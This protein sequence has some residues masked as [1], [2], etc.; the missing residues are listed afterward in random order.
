MRGQ[1]LPKI[2]QQLLLMAKEDKHKKNDMRLILEANMRAYRND[3]TITVTPME[4]S[5]ML[6]IY[7]EEAGLPE[8]IMRAKELDE[9]FAIDFG[10]W[11]GY[12]LLNTKIEGM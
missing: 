7:C 6:R 12:S 3:P 11:L 1:Q 8:E 9:S 10:N 4:F 5:R 2:N